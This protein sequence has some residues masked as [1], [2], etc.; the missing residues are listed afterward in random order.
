[1]WICKLQTKAILVVSLVMKMAYCSYGMGHIPVSVLL[2]LDRGGV[3][4]FIY[5]TKL[6]LLVSTSKCLFVFHIDLHTL[7]TS[8]GHSE[9]IVVTEAKATFQ[10]KLLM[11]FVFHFWVRINH[12]TRELGGKTGFKNSFAVCENLFFCACFGIGPLFIVYVFN[13]GYKHW[14]TTLSNAPLLSN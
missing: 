3:W 14:N 10:Y 9:D 2:L 5:I 11:V 1:M 4:C 8:C 12:T 7:E 6:S 13:V